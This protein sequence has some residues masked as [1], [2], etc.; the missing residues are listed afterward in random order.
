MGEE[1]CVEEVCDRRYNWFELIEDRSVSWVD[2]ISSD[3]QDVKVGWI[4]DSSES[5]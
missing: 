1:V 5:V 3:V 4:K 2:V